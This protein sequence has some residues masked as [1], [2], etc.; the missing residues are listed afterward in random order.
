M[1][2]VKKG[3]WLDVLITNEWVGQTVDTI[4][5]EKWKTPKKLLHQYRME[6]NVQLNGTALSHFNMQV[7]KGD[8]LQIRLFIHEDYGVIPEYIPISIYYEDDHL[9][10]VGKPAGINTHP[11]EGQGHTLANAVAFHLQSEGISTKVRHIHRL[12]KETSGGIVFAKHQL[13]G[14]ALDLLLEKRQIS[15]T[16]IAFVHGIVKRKC[17]TINERIGRDRHHP[18]RRRVST[19]GDSAVTHYEVAEVFATHNITMLKIKLDT[20][21]THQIRVHLSYLGHPIVADKLY[22]GATARGLARQA[23]HAEHISFSHPFSNEQIQV[24]IPWPEDLMNLYKMIR[25]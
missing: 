1:Q 11:N 17:G 10:I 8:R 25:K 20:G 5:K 13:A 9:L 2:A 7:N 16:Y 15:R 18:S 3:E 19:S 14:T 23:L 4:L 12:D 22:G 24:S 6:K 21:R